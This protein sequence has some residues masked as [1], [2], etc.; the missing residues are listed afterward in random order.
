MDRSLGLGADA[1]AGDALL[2]LAVQHLELAVRRAALEQRL[3]GVDPND[4]YRGLLLSDEEVDH[5]LRI[6]PAGDAGPPAHPEVEHLLQQQADLAGRLTALGC[7][8]GSRLGR[9]L[10]RLGLTPLDRDILLLAILAE[11]DP[12]YGRLLAFLQDDVTRSRPS[13]FLALRLFAPDEG[14]RPLVRGRFLAG[15]PL[16]RHRLVRLESLPADPASALLQ[17]TIQVDPRVVAYLLNAGE[18]DAAPFPFL[19]RVEGGEALADL[20]LPDELRVSLQALLASLGRE[21]ISV[22][23][24]EGAPG[25]GRRTIARALAQELGRPLLELLPAAEHEGEPPPRERARLALR[26]ALLQGALLYAHDGSGVDLASWAPLVAELHAPLLLAGEHFSGGKGTPAGAARVRIPL[27][28]VALRESLWADALA[29]RAVDGVRPA[30][31]AARYRLNGGQVRD[32][33]SWAQGL[34][35]SRGRTAL[36]VTDLEEAIAFVVTPT[37]DGLARPIVARHAWGEIVLPQ[38]VQKHLREF[39][40][41][42]RQRDQV[43]DRW[44]FDR[45]RPLGR[46]LNA[47]FAGPSGTGKTMAAEIIAGEL[48]LPLLKIDLSAVVSKYVG[49]T[50]KHLRALFAEAERANAILFFDEADALFGKRSEVRDAHDR[51]ANIEVAYLLQALEEHAGVTILATN[52]YGNMDDAFVRRMHFIV[53]F[54]FPDEAM[55]RGIWEV[56]FPEQAPL[57]PDVDR[58]ELARRYRVTGGHIRNIALGAA[59]LAAEDGQVIRMSHLLQAARREF[60]K[61]G[62]IVSEGDFGPV[63]E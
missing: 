12:R 47:L 33:V 43:Y 10:K 32:A 23:L 37:L 21:S 41:A 26:E 20:L 35:Y 53:H 18:A 63:A 14:A 3:L 4:P 50:E 5:L 34:A 24:L 29:D 54:P 49:E 60:Q 11:L 51:Y 39:V 17:Q 57:A 59:F 62:K 31:L 58:V 13:V 55:R 2:A 7:P 45:R 25:S 42:I 30:D 61:M 15:A 22:V 27:P 52:L 36:Q 6:L 48:A 38:D 19:R 40:A 46:G 8:A 16:L 56:I 1:A 44:G 9:L 28:N